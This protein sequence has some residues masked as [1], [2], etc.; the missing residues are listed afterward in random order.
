MHWTHTIYIFSSSIVDKTVLSPLSIIGQ[1][2]SLSRGRIVQFDWS[3]ATTERAG[4]RWNRTQVYPSVKVRSVRVIQFT[5]CATTQCYAT[6]CLH[7]YCQPGLH[8]HTFF[9]A[10]RHST[11]FTPSTLY[12]MRQNPRDFTQ[13]LKCASSACF[14]RER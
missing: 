9:L 6:N 7:S 2:T 11:I 10:G 13:N 4:V 8:W 12:S 1:L 14:Q 5:I 3:N